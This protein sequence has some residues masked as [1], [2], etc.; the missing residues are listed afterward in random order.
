MAGRVAIAP[1]PKAAAVAKSASASASTTKKPTLSQRSSSTATASNNPYGSTLR[2]YRKKRALPTTAPFGLSEFDATGKRVISKRDHLFRITDLLRFRALR[3]G[4][5]VAARTT[6]RDLWILARVV[7]DYPTD[8]TTA[9]I[10]FLQLSQARR[11]NLF[12]DKVIVQDVE[13]PKGGTAV[14][15][16]LVLPLPRTSAE[17]AEWLSR[18]KKG[19]RLY[20]MYPKTTS[21]YP[22]TIIDSTT[23]CKG[24]EDI[25]VVDFDGEEMDHTG[26]V[27]HHHIAAQE[28]TVIP[29]EFPASAT[30][31]TT[32]T[33]SGGKRKSSTPSSSNNDN[34][35]RSRVNS[36]DDA[37]N[38]MIS[39]IGG[40]DSFDAFDL[41]FAKTTD[42]DIVD[43]FHSP[44]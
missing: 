13:D 31:S 17:A 3:K 22:A 34:N 36:E 32:T 10:E 29:R 16:N 40:L 23:Y 11:D 20:A 39:Q 21:L 18:C 6:S 41:D 37:L 25:V 8:I 2:K 5:L 26:K 27:P 19:T 9:P 38:N 33:K 30:T 42:A 43:A 28:V 12:K 24:D 1:S 35:K 44:R 15:R 7:K 4:D 14:S